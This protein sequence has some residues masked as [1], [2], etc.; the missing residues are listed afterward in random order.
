MTRSCEGKASGPVWEA[1][2]NAKIISDFF[3]HQLRDGKKAGQS[4]TTY[5]LVSKKS[6][7]SEGVLVTD[8][9]FHFNQ[10]AN[11]GNIV[12]NDR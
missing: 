5:R 10:R 12:R 4:G 8:C 11:K 7:P 2:Q 9:M 6:E 3:P 1:E